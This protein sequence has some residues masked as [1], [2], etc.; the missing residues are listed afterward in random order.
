MSLESVNIQS[1]V[2]VYKQIENYVQFAISSGKLKPGD[3]LP[4]VKALGATLGVNFNT[5]AKAYRDLEVMG[6]IFA[7][8]G[9]GCY[10]SDNTQKE[11]AKK[12]RAHIVTRLHE[13]SQE[14][15]AAS[16]DKKTMMDTLS[17]SYEFSGPIYG[18]IPRS[19]TALI[20]KKRRAS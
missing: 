16:I 12:S 7:R 10:I 4:S 9:L 19:V 5:V 6:F 20:K 17:A 14:A 8:R 18:D 11:C 3:K 15:K 1:N 13:V 2:P